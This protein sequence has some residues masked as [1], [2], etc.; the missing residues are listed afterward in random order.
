METLGKGGKSVHALGARRTW[1]QW[2]MDC[3]DKSGKLDWGY[4]TGASNAKLRSKQKSKEVVCFEWYFRKVN[5]VLIMKDG[6][7]IRSI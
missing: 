1:Q 4:I 6:L 5:V 7:V 2:R 3:R